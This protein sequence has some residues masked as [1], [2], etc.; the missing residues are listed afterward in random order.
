MHELVLRLVDISEHD[1]YSAIMPLYPKANYTFL[2]FERSHI[3]G[4]KYDAILKNKSTGREVKVP[5]GAK[6]YQQFKDRALGLYRSQDHGDTTRRARYIA[7]HSRDIN[8]AYS[9]SWFSLK[10]LW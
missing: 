6:G 3:E 9:P 4:K 8:T 2:R 5:F 7:R 1:I 10:Y